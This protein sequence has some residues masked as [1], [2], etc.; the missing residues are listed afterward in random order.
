MAEG[1]VWEALQIASFYKLDNLIGII[2][3]NRL[4]Q[5][6]QTI[7]GHN[8]KAIAK[9]VSSFGWKTIMIDGHDFKQI[10]KAYRQAIQIKNKPT[11]IIAKTIKGKGVSFLENKNGWHG[12][13]LSAE[14]LKK[15]LT[16]LGPVNEKLRGKIARPIN[17]QP[18]KLKIKKQNIKED[19][20]KDLSTRKA[21]G[22]ALVNLFLKNPDMVVLDAE[23]SNSTYAE[24]FKKAYPQRFLEM[25]IAEQNMVGV[26]AGLAA[27]G[28]T[29][30]VS[31]FAAFLTRA[32]DQIRMTQYSGKSAN[33]NFVGSHAGVSI[34]PDGSSQMGLEDIAMFRTLL[35]S[36]VLYP[37]DHISQEKL[38]EQAIKYRGPTYLRTT[39]MAT[40]TLYK[41]SDKFEIGGSKTLRTSS[42]DQI[43][44]VAAGVTLYEALRAYE[45]LKES[46]VY[47]RV[48]DLYSIKPIDKKTLKEAGR[49]TQA[50][51]TVEDHFAEGGIGEAVRSALEPLPTPVYS[52]AVRRMTKSGEPAEL[53]RYEGIDSM[54]IVRKVRQILTK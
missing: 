42:R 45:E 20:Q 4:G 51:I 16:E 6:G 52:L 44:I 53:L 40:P 39:R 14:E 36:V 30:F 5:R 13:T 21:Y 41:E 38:V 23:V 18:V 19:Y 48:I 43:T 3:V 12:K 46:G 2:D 47:V 15:A 11:M 22:H 17:K 35:N 25:F 1:S 37:S 31:T 27:R 33:I 34:G 54:A 26:A 49:N 8:L 50:I 9:K 7:D 29:P 24:T 32:F 28:K 10:T